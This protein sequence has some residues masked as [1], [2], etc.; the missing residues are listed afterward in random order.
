[1]LYSRVMKRATRPHLVNYGKVA[2]VQKV[3]K[4]LYES[5]LQKRGLQVVLLQ[6]NDGGKCSKEDSCIVTSQ[7][8]PTWLGLQQW[9]GGVGVFVV[10]SSLLS[11][12]STKAVIQHMMFR[13]SGVILIMGD[14]GEISDASNN[15]DENSKDLL[16]LKIPQYLQSSPSVAEAS[17]KTLGYSRRL[18]LHHVLLQQIKDV[19]ATPP[20]EKEYLA[21][22]CE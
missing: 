18:K 20:S 8:L 13:S 12:E 15:S 17:L 2:L 11:S 21:G 7:E 6:E 22:Q 14:E 10:G 5:A 3:Y 4:E 19:F 1:M 9:N 16:V